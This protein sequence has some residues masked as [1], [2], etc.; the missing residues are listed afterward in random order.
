MAVELGPVDRIT[1]GAV[2]EPGGR[3]FYLQARTGQ[4]LV[5]VM[6]EKQ[7]VE[8]LAASILDILERVGK[9]TEEGPAEEELE[10]EEPLEPE[11]RVGKL[12]IGY[13]EDRDL[14][15]L[16]LE[17]LVPD[18]EEES[19]EEVLTEIEGPEP[20]TIRLWATRE[21]MLALS[22]HGAAVAAR[23]RPACQF[24]GNPIDPE[25]HTCPAMNGHGRRGPA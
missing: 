11:W 5:T 17:E 22:R 23:G 10:L 4:R 1:T 18:D 8:L 25:G 21:Q 6:V 24:C 9:E 13:A 12:S 7:Q 19:E 15:L 14:L 2:G 3:T 20:D 16:E